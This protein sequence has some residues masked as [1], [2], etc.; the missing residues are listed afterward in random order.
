MGILRKLGTYVSLVDQAKIPLPDR[1]SDSLY[2]VFKAHEI[3]VKQ[4]SG[5]KLTDYEL[6]KA[7][8]RVI[9]AAVYLMDQNRLGGE[10]ACIFQFE[11]EWFAAEKQLIEEDMKQYQDDLKHGH[12]YQAFVNRGQAE[13]VS[14]LWLDHPRSIFF[15]I[16]AWNDPKSPGG[17]GYQFLAL[18]M[19]IPDKNR[20]VIGV[21]PESGTDLQGLGQEMERHES[22][23]RKRLGKERPVHPVRKPADNSDPWYFGQGHGYAVIDSPGEGTVLT[24]EEV[25]QI[26]R[27]WKP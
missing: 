20:F 12:T 4:N 13:P 9:D 22:E 17:K 25:E 24:A 26:H 3:L 11:P 18:D 10:F 5:G 14:G 7:Q 1:M 15:R 16:W 27:N 23:K 8:I 19:S 21:D 2:G 6:L